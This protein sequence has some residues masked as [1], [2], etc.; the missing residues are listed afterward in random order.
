MEFLQRR[1]VWGPFFSFSRAAATAQ[2][3]ELPL[4]HA[5]IFPME[6]DK[7]ALS[8]PHV[9]QRWE[10]FSAHQNAKQ[11]PSS[12]AASAPQLVQKQRARLLPPPKREKKGE[13]KL[14]LWNN[15]TI[16]A[17]S[18]EVP[19]GLMCHGKFPCCFENMLTGNSNFHDYSWQLYTLSYLL[20]HDCRSSVTAN[21]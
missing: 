20:S 4:P 9:L 13:K 11:M 5:V 12:R 7:T 1:S 19:P 10:E 17:R 18:D 16:T 6:L 2:P 21:L 8:G 15:D 3:A 14:T